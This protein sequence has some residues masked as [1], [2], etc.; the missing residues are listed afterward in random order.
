MLEEISSLKKTEVLHIS[1]SFNHIYFKQW[2]YFES[3]KGGIPGEQCKYSI[4]QFEN[5]LTLCL[6][7]SINSII[8]SLVHLMHGER[9]GRLKI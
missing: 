4:L 7:I 8:A 6:E 9:F 2:D 1:I 5:Y 3:Y